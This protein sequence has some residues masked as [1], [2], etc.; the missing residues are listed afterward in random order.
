MADCR[1]VSF[2]FSEIKGNWKKPRRK[3]RRNEDKNKLNQKHK[4]NEQGGGVE[5]V[6]W[7][8]YIYIY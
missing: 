7:N 6:T 8:V 5:C 4:V 3:E 2:S 1:A